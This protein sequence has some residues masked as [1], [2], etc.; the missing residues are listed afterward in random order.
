MIDEEAT[1]EKYG[2]H[3]TDLK[4]KS[5]K[6]VVRVCDVCTDVKD[7]IMRQATSLCWACSMKSPERRRKISEATTGPNHPMYGVHHTPES[8]QKISDGKS[9]VY[10]STETRRKMSETRL[11]TTR[12]TETRARMSKAQKGKIVGALGRRNMSEAHRGKKLS[13]VTRRRMSATTRGI[14]YDE[15]ESFAKDQRY[16]PKFDESCRESNREKYDRRCFL[17]GKDES[18]NGQHLSVHHVDMNKMQGC[19]DHHWKLVPLC[20]KHHNRATHTSIWAARIQYLLNV[21]YGGV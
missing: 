15:W 6:L 5:S 19:N 13:E 1:F 18:D 12:S 2:Y 10:P 7:V 21:V 20:R 9:G 4:P 16:C 17:C 3:S 14:P 8:K 11:G